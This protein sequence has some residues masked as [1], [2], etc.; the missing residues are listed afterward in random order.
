MGLRFIKISISAFIFAPSAIESVLHF[1]FPMNIAFSEISITPSTY[2]SPIKIP[3]KTRVFASTV[4][5]TT[6]DSSIT[7]IFDKLISPSTLP[8]ITIGSL[9]DI[10]PYI[11]VE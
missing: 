9:P 1:S 2:I 7:N 10:E 8:K 11:A 3:F 5:F 6:P 4:A